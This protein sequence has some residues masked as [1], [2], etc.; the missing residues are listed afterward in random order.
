MK[1]ARKGNGKV[2]QVLTAPN[3]E[4]H[5]LKELYIDAIDTGTVSRIPS[6]TSIGHGYISVEGPNGEFLGA[7]QYN[8]M[9]HNFSINF[10]SYQTE[11]FLRDLYPLA[12]GKIS[13]PKAAIT[14][15]RLVND[16]PPESAAK[17]IGEQ[18]GWL[19]APIKPH[20]VGCDCGGYLVGGFHANWCS[21][22]GVV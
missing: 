7:A 17:S 20:Q 10:Y 18:A 6:G 9:L 21:S 13:G 16:K 14:G 3:G 4:I 1:S 15:I 12:V 8:F 5:G 19:Q 22:V 2:I 11:D